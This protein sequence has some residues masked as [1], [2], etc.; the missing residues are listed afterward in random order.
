M[1][2]LSWLLLI[3]SLFAQQAYNWRNAEIVGGGFVPGVVFHP[4][5]ETSF[6]PVPT[7]AEPTAGTL[8]PGGGSL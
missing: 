7:S 4:A 1:W 2:K 8:L 6:T 5:K 3:P